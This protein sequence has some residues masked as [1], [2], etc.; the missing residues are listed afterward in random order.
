MSA[1]KQQV[2]AKAEKIGVTVTDHSHDHIS[3]DCPDGFVFSTINCHYSDYYQCNDDKKSVLWNTALD[4][5]S[6][7]IEECDAI[8]CE[9]C[10]EGR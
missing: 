1:T 5:M 10:Q 2:I 3:L 7:G 8:D 6:M 9:V 4:D